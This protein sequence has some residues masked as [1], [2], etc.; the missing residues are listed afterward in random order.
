MINNEDSKKLEDIDYNNISNELGSTSQTSLQKK[1]RK[2][3]KGNL[4]LKKKLPMKKTKH[5]AYLIDILSPD[6][7]LVNVVD[8]ESYKKYNVDGDEEIE[9]ENEKEKEE[10]PL[11]E[12]KEVTTQGCCF[13]F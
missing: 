1:F 7:K 2:D 11:E 12:S 13:V 8:I 4:I 5:H 10:K 3:A 9:E 6:K